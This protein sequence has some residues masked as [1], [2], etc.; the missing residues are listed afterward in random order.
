MPPSKLPPLGNSVH[1]TGML[2]EQRLSTNS[3]PGNI[4][5][6]APL[7][8][9]EARQEDKKVDEL[10]NMLEC[11]I[12]LDTADR[13]P[14]Y[15]CPEGHLLCS[16]CNSRLTECPQCGHA[17][18]NSRNRTA[19][20]LASKLQGLKGTDPRPATAGGNATLRIWVSEPQKVRK[21]LFSNVVYTITTKA[22]SEGEDDLKTYTVTRGYSEIA[23]LYEKLNFD[24][25]EKGVI[26]PPPPEKNRLAAVAM[27]F[28]PKTDLSAS[29]ASH[30]VEKRCLALDRYMKRMAR[31]PTIK[32]NPTFRAFIQEKDMPNVKTG[33]GILDKVKKKFTLFKTR[34]TVSEQDPWFQTR[35]AQLDALSK[36]LKE[37]RSNLKDMSEYKQKLYASASAFQRDLMTMPINKSK[38]NSN[39]D[40]LS[41]I[42]DDVVGCHKTMGLIH[43]EQAKADELVVDLAVDYERL[44][45]HSKEVIGQRRKYQENMQKARK[46]KK[47]AALEEI[48]K[49]Q[50]DFDKLSQSIRRELEHFD[51]VMREEFQE[52][53][54]AY[55]HQY[56]RSLRKSS[57]TPIPQRQRTI[58]D[59]E[60]D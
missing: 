48:E 37:M 29:V 39:N 25:Q 54:E 50:T 5:F 59:I 20:E 51:F 23:D 34:F 35:S 49:I 57:K 30:M 12:C 55:N 7:I 21:G 11:P 60:T 42:I 22:G 18:M 45:S 32:R 6:K 46:G 47:N 1:P 41:A 3:S 36:Q 2:T 56:W 13:A 10:M 19:E 31:H 24:L 27:N 53:F 14:I 4:A 58:D 8:D 16:E 17:L 40:G 38:N 28:E 9:T 43:Q 15:Q 52:A 33:Y 26:V 44:V